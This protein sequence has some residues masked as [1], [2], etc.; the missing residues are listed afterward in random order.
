MAGFASVPRIVRSGQPAGG[1]P[2]PGLHPMQFRGR[3]RP[4]AGT[5]PSLSF[6]A[7]KRQQCHT[8]LSACATP[9][10]QARPG[11]TASSP[12]SAG[13]DNR[14]VHR[15][16]RGAD[17]GAFGDERLPEELRTA[18]PR[19]RPRTFR[20]RARRAVYGA[21][22]QVADESLRNPSVPRRPTCRS[23]GMLFFDE[24]CAERWCAGDP[25][26]GGQGRRFRPLHA[27]RQRSMHCGGGRFGI[28]LGRDSPRELRVRLAIRSR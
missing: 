12:S 19:C 3:A 18:H 6:L 4:P 26:R 5:M 22:Q 2:R 27:G 23:R 8:K 10:A 15:P 28:V 11:A 14:S 1:P 7:I 13:I 9:A 21:W 24:G 16:C 20:C 25:V 17:R